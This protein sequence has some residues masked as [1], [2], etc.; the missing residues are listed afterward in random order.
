MNAYDFDNTILRGDSTARFLAFCARRYPRVWLH[1][2]SI[3]VAGAL[4]LMGRVEKTAFKQKMFEFLREIPDVDRAVA[5]FWAINESRIRPWY[6]E[7]RREGDVI[8]SASP[9]FLL[10]PMAQKLGARLIAS[11]VDPHTGKYSGANCHG[12]EKVRRFR[13]ALGDVRPEEF[14]SDSLSD[15]PMARLARRAWLVKGNSIRPWPFQ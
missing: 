9:E 1:A 13:A 15:E 8:I 14:Y 10:A 5:E 6:W 3:A 4:F 11:P 12:P 7:K 2:P